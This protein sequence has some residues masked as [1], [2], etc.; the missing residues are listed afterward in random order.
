MTG[1]SRKASVDQQRSSRV[2]TRRH[3]LGGAA[4]LGVGGTLALSRSPLTALAQD[5]TRSSRGDELG[6]TRGAGGDL[7]IVQWDAPTTLSVHTTQ[8]PRSLLGAALV[9]EPLLHLLPDGTLAP[10]LSEVVPTL[11]NGLLAPDLTA[12]TYRL[13]EG[14]VWSDG[15]PFTADDVVFTW[16]WIIDPVNRS[17]D[18]VLYE[19]IASVVAVDDLTVEVTFATPQPGWF[20]VFT[21]SGRGGIYPEHVLAGGPEAHD[22]F[23]RDP[24]GTGPYVVESLTAGDQVVIVFTVNQRYREPSKPFF[25]RVIIEGGG[26]AAAMA[27]AVFEAGAADMAPF[28][29]V[30]PPSDLQQLAQGQQGTLVVTPG[31]TVEH[32]GFNFSD[33]ETEVDG[34]PSHWQV[35]HPV[36]AD[37]V[38]RQALALAIDRAAIAD[39]LFLG[40]PGEPVATNILTGLPRYESPNTAWAYDPDRARAML[41]EAGWAMA[42]TSRQKE[43]VELA[44]RYVVP[45]EPVQWDVQTLVS[46]D[47]EALGVRVEAIQIHPDVLFNNDPGND[48]SFA[49]MFYDLH[50][51]PIWPWEPFPIGYM[52]R[53][54]S[55]DGENIAQ[56]DNLWRPPNIYRYHNPEYDALFDALMTEVE[57][58]RAAELLIEMNDLLIE[59]A[60]A[61][62]LVRQAAN[63]TAVATTLDTQPLQASPFEPITWNIANWR[64][65]P[66]DG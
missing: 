46:Q 52:N 26:D 55:H 24:V 3:L 48:W 17:V 5:T 62:P 37:R 21:T 19:P 13:R 39:S 9:T 58:T 29:G 22:L 18:A 20:N 38:V 28:L 33:P 30:L 34:S 41:D 56:R 12:V 4:S 65:R 35:P 45:D 7:R 61:I 2:I 36:L 10:A 15:E 27:E 40:A 49:H 43:G 50:Q 53:W 60:V 59:D 32:I 31:V 1:Q 42:G 64:R 25:S 14:V 54:V 51:Y 8:H 63:V 23:F 57:P 16:Q 6:Q 11:E 47:W 44:L 66:A